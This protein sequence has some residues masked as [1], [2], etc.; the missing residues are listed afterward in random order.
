MNN[1]A[2]KEQTFR[3]ERPSFSSFPFVNPIREI[4][5]IRGTRLNPLLCVPCVL[6][7]GKKSALIRVNQL[8]IPHSALRIEPHPC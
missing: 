4:R 7:G 5:E 6:C 3:L 1:Q 2:T 8:R